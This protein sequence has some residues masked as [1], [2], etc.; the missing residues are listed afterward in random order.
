M[1]DKITAVEYSVYVLSPTAR[2][3]RAWVRI[4]FE[5]RLYSFVTPVFVLFCADTNHKPGVSL[6]YVRG[7]QHIVQKNYSLKR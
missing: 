2:I 3:V 7:G 6:F 1:A 4:T 5:A